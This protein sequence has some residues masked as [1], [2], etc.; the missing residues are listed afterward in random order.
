M[1]EGKR[2]PVCLVAQP[3]PRSSFQAPSLSLLKLQIGIK[4]LSTYYAP[5]RRQCNK[6][7][8]IVF[9]HWTPAR[10][11]LRKRVVI[12]HIGPIY[13]K[14]TTETAILLKSD[15]FSILFIYLFQQY[16]RNESLHCCQLVLS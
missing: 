7:M 1:I 8:P 13:S 12:Y 14:D 6:G 15:I 9:G 5:L 2:Q 10:H 3:Q 11:N 4:Q 16:L